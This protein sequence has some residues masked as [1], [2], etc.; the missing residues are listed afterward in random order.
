M[1]LEQRHAPTLG[2]IALVMVLAACSSPGTT[3][4]PRPG[5]PEA[6]TTTR[7]PVA[8]Q[9][10][11]SQ[12]YGFRLT[13]AAGWSGSDA[14]LEW[15]GKELQ[16]LS[17]PAFA[18]FAEAATGR[19]FTVGA[20]RVAEGT[21]LAAWR[22]ALGLAAPAGCIDSKSA[23]KV[24]L[25]GEPAL[26]WTTD[27]GDARPRKIATLH[28]GR[29]YIAIFELSAADENAADRRVLESIRG[30]FRFTG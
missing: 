9:E 6:A 16:G 24:T 4:T 11:V 3:P 2:L 26:T 28:G 29:G 25:G 20:A 23:E 17:S 21:Q 15:D 18:D 22:A 14:Q 19:A 1:R 5:P 7:P 27:C 30:S 12:R 13:L 10:F 8:A